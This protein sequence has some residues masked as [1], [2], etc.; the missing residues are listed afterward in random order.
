MSSLVGVVLDDSDSAS[1]RSSTG[2]KGEADERNAAGENAGPGC[3]A[4]VGTRPSL[5]NV[6]DS[7]PESEF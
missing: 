6:A 4:T 3:T 5:T 2:D 7:V 1:G